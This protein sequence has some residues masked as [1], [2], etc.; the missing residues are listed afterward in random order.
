MDD[1]KLLKFPTSTEER[2]KANI[3]RLKLDLWT[4]EDGEYVTEILRL[5]EQY[6]MGLEEGAETSIALV[7]LQSSIICL[8]QYF[9]ID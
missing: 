6:V 3:D 5:C 2:I 8:D 4:T 9:T 1:L 7:N